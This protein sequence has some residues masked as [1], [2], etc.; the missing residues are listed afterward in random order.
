MEVVE[1]EITLVDLPYPVTRRLRVPVA[2]TLLD[3][4]KL[5]QAAMP[6]ED[7]HMFEFSLGR[8]LR[9]AKSRDGGSARSAGQE[10]LADVLAELGRKRAF[11]YTYDMGD[12][13]EHEI[14]P[15][16]P[17][18]LTPGEAPVALLAAEGRC[19]PED[20]GGAP[21]FGHLLDVMA[22]P[23]HDEHEDMVDWLGDDHPWNPAADA[24]A[25]AAAV[26]IVGA[27]IAKRLQGAQ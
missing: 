23:T 21:G 20:S 14:R 15:G 24:A 3:L 10:R 12:G 16:K 5:M 1:I 17:F 11:L 22:D 9:W 8:T 2:I 13:W 19:P 7:S 25:L 6:W 27:R 4:H 26:K 18:D